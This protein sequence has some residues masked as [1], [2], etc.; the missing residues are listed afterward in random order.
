[1]SSYLHE[2]HPAPLTL[3]RV[4][5]A[6]G[7]LALAALFGWMWRPGIDT[8]TTSS[9]TTAGALVDFPARDPGCEEDE[10]AVV[11]P[12]PGPGLV[13]HCVHLEELRP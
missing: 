2:Q 6:G 7:A 11:A 10:A 1:M 4:A 3:A 5:V 13:W 9:T 12:I 8:P